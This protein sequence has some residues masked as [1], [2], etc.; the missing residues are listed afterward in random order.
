MSFVIID[1]QGFKTPE[2]VPKEMAI[3]DGERI[4]H[5]VFKEP[6]PFKCLS[7]SLQRQ[8]NWLTTNYHKLHW[9][10]GDV[11]LS[12]IP[13]ILHDIQRYAN[14]IYCKGKMKGD[15]LKKYITKD[16]IVCDLESLS[17]L[18]CVARNQVANAKCF[19]HESGVCAIENVKLLYDYIVHPF[20]L[21]SIS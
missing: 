21:P 11:D 3:W 4:A 7:A 13:H 19:Y 15:F 12:R 17:C 5:Y 1:L 2:F 18:R 6:F 10:D 8:A 14:V 20:I 16:V 9:T